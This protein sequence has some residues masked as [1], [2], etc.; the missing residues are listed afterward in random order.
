MSLTVTHD[1]RLILLMVEEN[2]TG[3]HMSGQLHILDEKANMLNKIMLPETIVNPFDVAQSA[4][5]TFIIVYGPVDYETNHGVVKVNDEGGI[6]A[7]H[8]G[9]LNIPISLMPRGSVGDFIVADHCGDKLWLFDRDLRVKS[10]LL[11]W[12]YDKSGIGNPARVLYDGKVGV[13]VVGLRSGHVDIFSA[14]AS[15]RKYG[16]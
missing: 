14:S 6:V 16:P 7:S 8:R 15:G 3:L 13:L 5:N 4:D 10:I 9:L 1:C 11:Q 2:A 12:D